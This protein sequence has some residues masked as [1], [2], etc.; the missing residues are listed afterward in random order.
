M[1][2]KKFTI[3]LVVR[4]EGSAT[5]LWLRLDNVRSYCGAAGRANNIV[6]L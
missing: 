2:E 6:L 4:V 1:S 3:K 5:E